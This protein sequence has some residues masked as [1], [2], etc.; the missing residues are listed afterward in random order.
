MNQRIE[1]IGTPGKPWGEA[2]KADW[3]ARQAR[4]RSH[5]E[6][7]MAKVEAW[8]MTV[9]AHSR[10]SSARSSMRVPK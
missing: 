1:T 4:Q 8:S 9:D 7:V 10:R 6:E 5:A 3:R 2:E